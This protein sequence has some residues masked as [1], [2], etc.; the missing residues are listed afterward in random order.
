MDTTF[1]VL[2]ILG[3][4]TLL[5]SVWIYILNKR[6]IKSESNQQFK[7]VRYKAII[8]LAYSLVYFDK[9]KPL[10]THRPEINS[11]NDIFDELFIEWRNMMLYAG[12]SVI[13]SMKQFLENSNS[14]T[15]NKLILSMRKDLY[16]INTKISKKDLVLQGKRIKI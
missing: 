15:L 16:G 4:G 10:Q 6:K 12:D 2:T 3:I 13:L 5:N 9:S 1:T 8:I 7:D 11:K 14:D